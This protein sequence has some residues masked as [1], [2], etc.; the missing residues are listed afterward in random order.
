MGRLY[1][2]IDITV[3][4]GKEGYVDI[5]TSTI[6][7]PKKIISISCEKLAS[8]DLLGKVERE[9]I[10]DLPSDDRFFDTEHIIID[11]VLAVGE[12]LA[13]GFR[14]ATGDPQ[15]KSISVCYEIVT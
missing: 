8:L 9:M 4:D 2:Q 10:I 11:R 12:T 5:L 14:N 3:A 15:T 1:T 6:A 7:E 13:V